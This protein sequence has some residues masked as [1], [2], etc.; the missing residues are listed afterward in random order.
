MALQKA[1]FVI[2]ADTDVHLPVEA[3]EIVAMAVTSSDDTTVALTVTDYNG[4]TVATW[5]SADYTTRTLRRLGVAEASI[6]DTGGDASADTE[7]SPIGVICD[8]PLDMDI[9]IDT[10]ELLVEVF[11]RELKKHTV[12]ATTTNEDPVVNLGDFGVIKAIAL[13]ADSDT[14]VALAATD[15]NSKTLSTWASADYTT[16]TLRHL[17][18]VETAVYDTGGDASANTEGN[19]VGVLFEGDV[20]LGTTGLG[21]DG[22]VIEVYYE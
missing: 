7:H 3:A 11:F 13:T 19:E 12:E 17:A 22:L 18:E 5:A 10:G 16:R 9:T 20:T 15:A 4:A 1:S 21:A 6:Y 8:S 14:T 2:D